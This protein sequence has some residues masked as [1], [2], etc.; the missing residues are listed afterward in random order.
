MTTEGKKLVSGLLRDLDPEKYF[1]VIGHALK[2]YERFLVQE[3]KKLDHPFEIFVFVPGTVDSVS[4]SRLKESGLPIRV[5][6]EPE[7]LGIYKSVTYEI[8]KR[9]P[10]ILIGLDGNSAALNMIQDAKNAKYRSPIFL[11][12]KVRAFKVKAA[13]LSGYIR[14]FDHADDVLQQIQTAQEN[15]NSH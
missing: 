13:S 6:L 14:L 8:F 11:Y 1:F 3:N 7:E 5:S 12:G 15:N 10:Y 4:Q 9:R 2:A